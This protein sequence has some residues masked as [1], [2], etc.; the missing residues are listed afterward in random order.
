MA[1]VAPLKSRSAW[2]A[3][4]AEHR[5]IAGKHLRELFDSDPD[6][7]ERLVAEALG[8]Y[9]DYS[10]NRVMD[11]TMTSLVELAEQSGLRDHIDAMFR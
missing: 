9:L 7:G 6:R 2:S 4:E 11:S 3:L 5:S 1:D 10:K 8:L